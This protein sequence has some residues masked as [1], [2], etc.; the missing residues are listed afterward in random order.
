MPKDALPEHLRDRPHEDWPFPFS[1]IPRAWTAYKWGP[2]KK[3]FGNQQTIDD[4]GA[5]K[6]IGP[7]GTWQVSYYPEAPKE[8]ALFNWYVALTT[9]KGIHYRLG[10]RWD[11]IDKYCTILSVARKDLNKVR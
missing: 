5:P 3:L 1:L 10:T 8:W 11:D 2:P 4:Q 9:K 6:P 7:P